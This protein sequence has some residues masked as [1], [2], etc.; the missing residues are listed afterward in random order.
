MLGCLKQ[1]RAAKEI[2]TVEGVKLYQ[3]R[4]RSKKE[5]IGKGR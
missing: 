5:E 3:Q 4:S 1:V 2:D